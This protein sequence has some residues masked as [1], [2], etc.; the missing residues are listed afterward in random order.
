MTTTVSPSNDA[1]PSNESRLFA[2]GESVGLFIVG[3]LTIFVGLAAA[4]VAFGFGGLQ[5][6]GGFVVNIGVGKLLLA[7]IAVAYIWLRLGG[8]SVDLPSRC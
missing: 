2:I 3:F 7:A 6:V 4:V 5:S 1:Q 8:L